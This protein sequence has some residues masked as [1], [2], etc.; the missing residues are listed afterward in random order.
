MYVK[1]KPPT[2]SSAMLNTN[3]IFKPGADH[4]TI[5]GVFRNCNG[6]WILGFINQIP[7]L[8]PLEDELHALLL[9]L[10]VAL[11]HCFGEIEIKLDC[12]QLANLSIVNSS[13]ISD[14]RCLL[15]A[16]GKPQVKHV[17][18]EGNKL[19]DALA[20][21]NVHTTT[22]VGPLLLW[23]PPAS[24]KDIL[25]A[26][27]SGGPITRRSRNRI[28]AGSLYNSKNRNAITCANACIVALPQTASL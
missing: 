26:N 3:A 27:I 12:Q 13:L 20:R 25:Q 10:T 9:G 4:A 5:T 14:C 22:T 17:Y 19:A 1:W 28:N 6:A 11:E 16:L 23:N 18:R 15:L 24:I 2:F 21:M 8:D 7:T